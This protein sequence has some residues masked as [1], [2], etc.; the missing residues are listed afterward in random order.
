MKSIGKDDRPQGNDALNLNIPAAGR[1]EDGL[2]NDQEPINIGTRSGGRGPD[3]GGSDFV[4]EVDRCFHGKGPALKW[5][6]QLREGCITSFEELKKR[7]TRTYVGRVR[8]DKDEHSFMTIKK[9]ENEAI[10]SFQDRFQTE[11]NLVRGT[12]QK[13]AIITFIEGLMM[14]TFKESLLNKRHM[15]LEEVNDRAYKYIRIEEDEKRDEKGSGKR[16][17]EETRRRIPEP[18]RRR[19]LNR[20]RATDGG[21]SRA[22]LPRSNTFSRLQDEQKK[23]EAKGGKIEYLTPVRASVENIFLEIE[24][25]RMLPRPLK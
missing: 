23:K 22:D 4:A 15:S 10:W 9:K 5:F 11:F 19:A 1:N 21:Y 25:K 3:D 17:M 8:Q 2:P 18:K 16:L 24:D 14:N 7:F 13:I 20:I 12:D 6:N